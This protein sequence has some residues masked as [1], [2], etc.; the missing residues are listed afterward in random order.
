MVLLQGKEEYKMYFGAHEHISNIS[1][2]GD[3]DD[4]EEGDYLTIRHDLPERIDYA[5][6]K[7]AGDVEGN[8]LEDITEWPTDNKDEI[9]KLATYDYMVDKV[10]APFSVYYSFNGNGVPSPQVATKNGTEIEAYS[11]GKSFRI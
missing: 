4:F 11:G 8:L 5:E 6:I 7:G 10:A 1:F 3:I 9:L 2:T